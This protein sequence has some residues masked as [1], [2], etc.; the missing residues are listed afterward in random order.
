VLYVSTIL[1]TTAF[2]YLLIVQFLSF[3]GVNRSQNVWGPDADEFKPERWLDGNLDKPSQEI[4]C[5]GP[6]GN[7]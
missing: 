7:L 2:K 5:G 4:R 6:Y 3:D 1:G